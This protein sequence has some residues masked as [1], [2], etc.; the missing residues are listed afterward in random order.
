MFNDDPTRKTRLLRFREVRQRVGLSRSTIT[1]L[2]KLGEFPEHVQVTANTIGWVEAD[3]DA[4]VEARL[5]GRT[6]VHS[7]SR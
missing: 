5:I 6:S 3:I 4:W 7:A 2:Q 1:R